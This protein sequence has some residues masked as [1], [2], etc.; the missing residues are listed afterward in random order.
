MKKVILSFTFLALVFCSF[1]QAKSGAVKVNPLGLAFGFINFSYERAFNESN[2]GQLGIGVISADFG[3]TSLSGFGISPE[4]RLYSQEALEG[5]YWGPLV[6]F[7]SFN[8]ETDDIFGS[9]DEASVTA[10]G[11]GAKLGWNW[12]LGS[13]DSFVIDLGLGAQYLATSI[14][15]KS[16]SEDS[17]DLGTF[18]GIAPIINFS[19]GYAFD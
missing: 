3:S 15:V 17:F 13:S 9:R 18:D 7:S 19:I 1:S 6:N 2:S 8:A 12:L 11:A 5:F 10:F 4:F 14:D 16:G